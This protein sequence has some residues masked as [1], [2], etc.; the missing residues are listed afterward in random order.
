[1]LQLIDCSTVFYGYGF[2]LL[3]KLERYQAYYVVL[4]CWALHL[5]FSSLGCAATPSGRATGAGGR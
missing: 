4:G 3:G 2:G 1:M 5:V